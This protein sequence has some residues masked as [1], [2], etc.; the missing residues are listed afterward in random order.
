MMEKSFEHLLS[1]LQ[2]PNTAGVAQGDFD[3]QRL[4]DVEA[5]ARTRPHWILI[6]HTLPAAAQTMPIQEQTEPLNHDVVIHGAITDGE[7]RNIRFYRDR[8]ARPIVRYG[9]EVNTKLSLDA[10]AGHSVATAGLPGME[11]FPEPFLIRAQ[12]LLTVEMYQETTPGA[13]ELVNTV[14]CGTR[15]FRPNNAEAEI[16]PTLRKTIQDHIK[17]RPAPEPRF[18]ICKVT[19]DA[20]GNALTE[21]PKTE[22]PLICLGFRSTF[23][24]ALINL[25]FDSDNSFSK[26]KFPIWA[27][28]NEPNN[29]KHIFLPLKRA[30]FIPPNQQLLM[31]LANSIDGTL[32]ATDGN[33]E[34][35]LRSV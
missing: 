17:L 13:T 29:G 12:G 7:S 31:S 35:L 18:A 20:D 15:V 5:I 8:E 21:T 32:N 28:A 27:L 11:E 33:I 3:R 6:Q 30:L 2:N 34:V 22:E 14:F 1:I 26:T 16:S 24:D 4:S 9:K 25:G 10:I 19:F 23:T